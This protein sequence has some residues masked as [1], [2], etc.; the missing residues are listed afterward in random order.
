M[1]RTLRPVVIDRCVADG[2]GRIG[3]VGPLAGRVAVVTGGATDTGRAAAWRLAAEGAS[4]ALV[5]A[6][7]VSLI[8]DGIA[9]TRS[10]S[11]AFPADVTDPDQV[12]AAAAYV[13][14]TLGP[15]DILV[16]NAGEGPDDLLAEMTIADWRRMFSVNVTSTFLT[17]VAFTPAMKARRW[18]RIVNMAAN[19]AGFVT[20][21]FM[22]YIASRVAIIGLTR[23]LA[24]ELAA[25]GVTVNAIASPLLHTRSNGAGPVRPATIDARM[26]AFN[27]APMPDDPVRALSYLVSDAATAITGQVFHVG[28]GTSPD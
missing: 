15:V 5:G 6:G 24:T 10:K 18:G 25:F 7:D 9:A 12:A 22:H 16:N 4:V 20:P 26:E 17:S 23:V 1:A 2:R 14:A 19:A 11:V 28:N 13:E 21:D 8:V 3:M 27:R